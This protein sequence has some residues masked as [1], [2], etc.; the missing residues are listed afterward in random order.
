MRVAVLG[1]GTMGAGMA[2][3]MLRAG[4]DV[5]AW[6]RTADRAEPLKAAGATIAGTVREAVDGADAVVTMMFDAPAVLGVADD[7]IAA[8]AA[9][10]VWV[11]SATIGLNGVARV[12]RLAGERGVTLLDAPM[13]GTKQP[14]DEGALVPLVAGPRDA[15]RR[16]QP[17]FEAIGAKTIYA[18]DRIGQA[19][20][21]KLA[22]NAWIA[23]VTAAL[24]QSLELAAALGIEPS[25]FLDAI[26]DGPSDTPYA[27]MKGPEML[28][29][30]YP[31]SFSVDGVLKDLGLMADAAGDAGFPQTLLTPVREA[32]ARASAAGHGSDDIAAV[33]TEFQ[34]ALASSDDEGN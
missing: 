19:M 34:P 8:L 27:H 4:L 16:V 10:A 28:D 2:R 23:T 32:Y 33:H 30:R 21:L 25:L 14:A 9:D 22:C 17:V 29:S 3:S 5:A 31:P 20:A 24:G 6:N 15:A 18:G 11:Q 12:G 1:T 26:A 13:L 7:L